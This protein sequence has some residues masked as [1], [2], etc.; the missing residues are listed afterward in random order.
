MQKLTKREKEVYNLIKNRPTISREIIANKLGI[1]ESAVGTYIYNL[2]KKGYILGKGYITAPE[3]KIVVIGGS[4]LDLKAYSKNYLKN[5]S[6]PGFVKESLGGVGRNIAE[7]LGILGQDVILLTAIGDDHFGHKLLAETKKSNVNLE[8]V[9]I[10]NNK[11]T[12]LY[13]AHLDEKGELIAAISD[14][15]IMNSIDLDYLKEKR[16]IIKNAHLVIFDT[17]LSIEAM[18]YIINITDKNNIKTLAETVSVDKSK[19]LID[20]LDKIDY[21]SPNIAEAETLLD[22]EIEI[23]KEL[24]Y[25]IDKVKKRYGTI[26]NLPTMFISCGEK[27]VLILNNKL[28]KFIE[29]QK[30]AKREIVEATG[31]GDSLLA[32]IAD[33]LL[34]GE[35][36]E[37]AVRFAVKIAALTVKSEYTVNPN[38]KELLEGDEIDEK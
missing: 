10:S 18:E 15:E 14:M 1:S 27:G 25:R 31:A 19:K 35:K 3:K 37:K 2:T 34:K 13:L 6:N 22:L 5:T 12:G 9:K 11:R 26:N 23:E 36:L 29:A 16:K 38:L 20:Y 8:H 33:K 21:I 32:G 24:S 4:N 30:I 17:N 7:N 28:S